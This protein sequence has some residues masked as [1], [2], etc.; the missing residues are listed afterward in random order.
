[1]IISGVTFISSD[2][3]ISCLVV[4]VEACIFI[5]VVVLGVFIVVVAGFLVVDTMSLLFSSISISSSSLSSCGALIS[6][7]S[8]MISSDSTELVSSSTICSSNR[9]ITGGMSSFEW[10]ISRKCSSGCPVK[11]CHKVDIRDETP[12]NMLCSIHKG[13]NLTTQYQ[14]SQKPQY[15]IPFW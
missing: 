9:G 5:S 1:M 3:F 14:S 2:G 8:A 10:R 11:E 12:E 13:I 7:T 15:L 6:V 4:I